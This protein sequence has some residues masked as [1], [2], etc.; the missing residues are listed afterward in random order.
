M[1]TPDPARKTRR[2]SWWLAAGV[3]LLLAAA[4]LAGKNLWQQHRAAQ[5]AG[6]LLALAE[7]RLE[8]R[9]VSPAPPEGGQEE[10]AAGEALAGYEVDGIL[11]IPALELSLP[12]LADYSEELLRASVCLYSGTGGENPQQM[13]IAGHN[14]RAHFG[15]LSQLQPGDAVTYTAMTGAQSHWRVA[16]VEEISAQDPAALEQGGWDMTLLT[17]N[18]DLSLRLLVRLEQ[19]DAAG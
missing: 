2:G 10:A 5:S 11:T 9:E 8:Q 17:C 13:V 3:L 12:V 19:A 4:L 16:Q 14:Y 15:R 6:E 7:A 1:T 18:L